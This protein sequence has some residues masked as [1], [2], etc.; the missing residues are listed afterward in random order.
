MFSQFIRSTLAYLI[1]LHTRTALTTLPEPDRQI[2]VELAGATEEGMVLTRSQEHALP[3]R[4]LHK[5]PT[6]GSLIVLVEKRKADHDPTPGSCQ[7][8]S[9]RRRITTEPDFIEALQ[10][11]AS[12]HTPTTLPS[13]SQLPSKPYVSDDQ[14]SANH[15]ISGM[16]DTSVMPPSTASPDH[17][18]DMF[19]VSDEEDSA[20]AV[21]N[22][23]SLVEG[24][25]ELQKDHV[26]SESLCRVQ[27][28][29][30]ETLSSLGCSNDRQNGKDSRM[31]LSSLVE[32]AE[33]IHAIDPLVEVLEK[34]QVAEPMIESQKAVHKRFGSEELE[35]PIVPEHG[36]SNGDST[37][38]AIE[39][40]D[41]VS[42]VDVEI[43]DEAPETVTASV[44]LDQARAA[45]SEAA[46]VAKTYVDLRYYLLLLPFDTS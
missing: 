16:N 25:Y 31:E 38:G 40:T 15:D 2:S 3:D 37:S 42:E 44:G 22:G 30:D 11:D 35:V 7:A 23:S 20:S 39:Q 45:V 10:P 27:E 9:K 34:K 26:S 13:I 32:L 33:D 6:I 17:I 5:S 18:K 28:V 8:N 36:I 46:K 12:F 29:P 19:A 24:N 1:P 43:E 21:R 41:T 4:G 14:K